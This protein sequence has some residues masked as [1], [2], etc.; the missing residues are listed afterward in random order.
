MATVYK[1]TFTKPLP[2]G[3]ELFTRADL[4]FARW[5]DGKGKRR[6]ARVTTGRDGSARIAVEAATYTAKYRNGLG[7]IVERST[8]C[9]SKD[10]AL[11]VL[12]EWTHRAE[13]VRANVLTEDEDAVSA[14][15]DADL[16]NHFG[17]Y[18]D[19][20]TAKGVTE[21]HRKTTMSYLRRM[22]SDCGWSRLPDLERSKLERWLA[23]QVVEGISARSRNAYRTAAVSFVHWAVSTTRII[24]NPFTGIPKVNEKTDPRRQRRA[25]TEDE[26]AKLLAVARRRPALDAMTVRCGKRKGQAVVKLRPETRVRLELL[27]RERALIYKTL[28][29]TGLRKAELASLTVGQL[30]LDGPVAYAVL[31][32]ADEKNRQ[33]SDIPLRADLAEDIRRW[34]ACK[35]EAARAEANRLGRPVP[36]RLPADTRLLNVPQGLLRIMNLDLVMAGLARRLPNGK[37]EKRDWRGR[38]IDVHALRHSFG[39]HLSKGGVPL[40]T[41][42]AAMRHSDPSLTANVYTDPALLDV[43]GALDVLPELPLDGDDGGQVRATGTTD[44]GSA[45]APMLAP[46]SSK[47]GTSVSNADKSHCSMVCPN[48]EATKSVTSCPDNRNSPLTSADNELQNS[49]RLD[50]NQRPLDPQSSAL[51]RLSHAPEFS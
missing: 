21:D 45:L 8:G 31:H 25:L 29:L 14:H 34:V 5:Q 50:L 10:A 27:G 49:G 17:A 30:E 16:D 32:A 2:P 7:H 9:R 42:Q 20:L 35:L 23:L 12:N 18:E 37:I 15:Q 51:T 44:A 47:C 11:S 6:T 48:A 43:V 24:A 19:H 22:A 38:T 41:A 13:L 46:T 26:L 4:R 33:G 3:A 1:K 28:V 36:Q 40:R 39:T